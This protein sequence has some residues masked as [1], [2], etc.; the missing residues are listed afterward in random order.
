LRS[1][2]L[3]AFGGDRGTGEEAWLDSEGPQ[4]KLTIARPFAVGKYG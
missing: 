2:Q 3:E 4:H 1:R